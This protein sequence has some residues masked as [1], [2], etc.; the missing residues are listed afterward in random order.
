MLTAPAARSQPD[1]SDAYEVVLSAAELRRRGWPHAAIRAQVDARRWQRVGRAVILHN[2]TLH[3][4]ERR[5]VA[6]LNCGPRAV[7]T[8]FTAAE[9]HGLAGWGRQ[10]IHVLVPAGARIARSRDPMLRLHYT[11]NPAATP[12]LHARRLHKIAPALLV[13]AGTFTRPRPACGIL[14]AGVQQRLV[15]AEQLTD[16]LVAASRLRHHAA[17]RA[18]VRDIAQGAE[19]LSEID[20]VRLCRRFRLPRPNQQG[21]RLEPS[22][23]RRYLDAEWTRRD[24]RRLVVE[25]DGALHLIVRKWWDD[26]RRQ[27][28]LTIAGDIVLRFP[29]VIV[30]TEPAAVADQVRRALRQ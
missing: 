25:V 23:R 10:Q 13:A 7:L 4:G 20:F 21:V 27:N 2:G 15:S 18:A 8:A 26:Q 6:L 24:G 28:E 11:G 17:L 16:A 3:P 1:T 22:G 30:R 19:A 5:R 9:E 14:A 29:S 12:R